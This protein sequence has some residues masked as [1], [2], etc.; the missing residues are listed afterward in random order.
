MQKASVA[1]MLLCCLALPVCAWPQQPDDPRGS[2]Q[3]DGGEE[4]H[5]GHAD[6]PADLVPLK[7]VVQPRQRLDAGALLCHTE[8]ALQ[9]HQAAVVAR[10]SGGTAQEPT[11]CRF[12]RDMVAVDVLQ[13]DGPARTEVRL[14]DASAQGGPAVA[15]G[16]S[17]EVG[18]TDSMVRDQVKLFGK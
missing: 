5:H 7:P 9:Q 1:A 12:V 14:H 13:R 11:G 17:G 16:A 18:W 3:S 6:K 10:L 15:A 8:A 4:R 2:G